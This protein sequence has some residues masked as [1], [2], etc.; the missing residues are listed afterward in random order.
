MFDLAVQAG[1]PLIYIRTEDI[2]N[3]QRVLTHIAGE[4][5]ALITLPEVLGK[6][7]LLQ[8]FD[9]RVAFT[10]SECK[11]MAKLYNWCVDK[12]KTIIFVN[13]E[14]S[15]LQFDGGHLVA[16]KEMVTEYLESLEIVDEGD[17]AGLLPCFGGL[18][19]KD[20]DEIA[21]LTTTRDSS[22]TPRGVNETRRQ[23]VDR[24]KGITQVDTAMDYYVC[25]PML[26]NWLDS[27][28]KFFIEE[29]HPAL[30]PRG[31]LGDGPPG[32]GKTTA[33]KHIAATFGIPLYRLDLG[34]M[35]GRYVGDS[36]QALGA[37]LNQIDQVAPCVAILDE[38]EKV[39]Q[40]SGDSGV[41]SRLM[42]QLLWWLAE[43]KSR[44]FTVMTTNNVKLIPEELHREG[45]ID[46]TLM[47]MGVPNAVE[48]QEFALG[49]FKVLMEGV[50]MEVDKT[51][52]T[53]LQKRVKSLFADNLPVPQSKLTVAAQDVVRQVFLSDVK[54]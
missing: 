34:S 49:A 36:E 24:L 1:L 31:L 19:L 40:T 15:V 5:V 35:M 39:F 42:S 3:V 6:Q 53:L 32:T 46:A 11:S 13:T 51:H 54:Q 25:P 12:E 41:T 50:N 45:R 37:A 21:R 14:K 29:I 10:S 27:R 8:E 38:V 22:L 17:V 7:P 18:T 33:A 43:H 47:F 48:G 4:E 2:I 20:C 26:K 9:A 30:T 16:P 28:A 52:I 23:Y 44:V